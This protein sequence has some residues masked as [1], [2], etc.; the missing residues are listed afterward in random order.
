MASQLSEEEIYELARKR[1]R[2]KKDFYTHLAVYIVVNA[3][4][5]L[6]WYF[7]HGGHPWFI[8]PLM[9]WGIGIIFHALDVF[10]FHNQSGWEVSAV[11]KEADK[12]RKSL[13]K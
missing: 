1:V 11:E 6:I 9:G 2:Q 12:L 8:W 5:V 13:K 7:T 3:M 10:V 4:L